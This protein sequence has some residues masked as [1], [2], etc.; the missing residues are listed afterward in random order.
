[1]I[2]KVSSIA[3]NSSAGFFFYVVAILGFSNLPSYGFK[4]AIMAGFMVPAI[5]TLCA[6]L[7]LKCFS[8]WRSKTGIVLLCASAFT[9]FGVLTIA[10]INMD[11]DF[12]K[13][14]KPDSLTIFSDYFTGF[15]VIIVFAGFGWMLLKTSRGCAEQGTALDSATLHK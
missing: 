13:M 6:G 14:M 5:I 9:A 8:N 11:E 2:R 3:L 7:A 4:W 12:R 1:M 15:A 10:C